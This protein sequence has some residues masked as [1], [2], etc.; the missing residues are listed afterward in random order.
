M[1]KAKDSGS[2]RK[3]VHYLPMPLVNPVTLFSADVWLDALNFAASCRAGN[4]TR[5]PSM[6][7]L[8][9]QD[10]YFMKC[11][12]SSLDFAVVEKRFAKLFPTESGITECNDRNDEAYLRIGRQGEFSL[13]EYIGGTVFA[14]KGAVASDGWLVKKG[15]FPHEPVILSLTADKLFSFVGAVEDTFRVR[16]E[17]LECRAYFTVGWGQTQIAVRAHYE[18][19][20]P[21]NVRTQRGLPAVAWKYISPRFTVTVG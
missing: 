14:S 18:T 4:G 5:T 19:P 11:L 1:T 3:C 2:V 6:L 15:D 9:I 7:K 12:T 10:L 21:L 20:Q 16:G 13:H 8:E 17:T